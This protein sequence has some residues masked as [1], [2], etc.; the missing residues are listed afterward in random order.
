MIPNS[1]L[2]FDNFSKINTLLL[3]FSS[4]WYV[5]SI[6]QYHISIEL[7]E[8]SIHQ[9]LQKYKIAILIYNLICAIY[10]NSC[11][12]PFKNKKKWALVIKRTKKKFHT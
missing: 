4:E 10:M 7:I 8:L 11:S 1:F 5:C 12:H 9:K 2:F 3:N 6:Y